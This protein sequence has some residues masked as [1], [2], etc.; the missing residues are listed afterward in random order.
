MRKRVVAKKVECS[1]LEPADPLGLKTLVRLNDHETIS[2]KA[3]RMARLPA[4][5]LCHSGIN[6]N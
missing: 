5:H 6:E 3:I 4:S 1:I 2:N